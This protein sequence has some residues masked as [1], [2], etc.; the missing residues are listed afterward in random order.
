MNQQDSPRANLGFCKLFG[1]S[2]KELS[3][4]GF[5]RHALACMPLVVGG[6]TRDIAVCS[7]IYVIHC[8][9]NI[10][11]SWGYAL[12]YMSIVMCGISQWCAHACMSLIVGG[13]HWRL[14]SMLL[15]ICHS[16]WVTY[17]RVMVIC[18]CIR[19]SYKVTCTRDIVV[20]PCAHVTHCGDIYW[21]RNCMVV[22]T[23]HFLWV[24]C[25]G[26]VMA[27]SC[28]HVTHRG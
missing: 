3:D 19:A 14:S 24:T 4:L 22:R 10:L 9:R 26:L 27:C 28:E 11:E 8:G 6:S 1:G 12:A 20:C 16:S 7:Y 18:S 13:M 2:T 21:C 5:G 23:C 17:T 25:T 15:H